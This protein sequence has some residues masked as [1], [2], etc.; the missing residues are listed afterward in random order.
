MARSATTEPGASPPRGRYFT[1]GTPFFAWTAPPWGP[2]VGKAFGFGVFVCAIT[3]TVVL[4]A[5]SRIS[6][7][8]ALTEALAAALT[9][10]SLAI[11]M[12]FAAS[13]GPYKTAAVG[14]GLVFATFPARYPA[15]LNAA[16]TRAARPVVLPPL[17]TS[18]VVEPGETAGARCALP[19]E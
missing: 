5:P 4:L 9:P 7:W 19:G 1:Q 13:P 3:G 12:A 8:S 15:L 18:T 11:V 16:E 6:M 10:K 14:R 17:R 2:F